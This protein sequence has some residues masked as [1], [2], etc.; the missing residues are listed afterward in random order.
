MHVSLVHEAQYPRIQPFTA[1]TIDP[2]ML[3]KFR[4]GTA[5]NVT[6]H[7]MLV[8]RYL[9]LCYKV[10]LAVFNRPTCSPRSA[11]S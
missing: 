4:F 3:G 6:L 2:C 7:L 11:L 9:K 10:L 1:E 5:Q 8:Q